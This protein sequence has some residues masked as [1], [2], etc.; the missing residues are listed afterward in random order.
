MAFQH[1]FDFDREDVL[2][3]ANDLVAQAPGEVEVAVDEAAEVAGVLPAFGVDEKGMAASRPYLADA[4]RIGLVD[5]HFDTGSGPADGIEQFLATG[6]G[7][8]VVVG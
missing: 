1:T 6:H 3:A 2:A 7:R 4:V 5:V 8:T